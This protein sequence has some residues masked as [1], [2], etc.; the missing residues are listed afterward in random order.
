MRAPNPT[1]QFWRDVACEAGKFCHGHTR[2]PSSTGNEP[3]D[4]ICYLRN[5]ITCI[6]MKNAFD[7]FTPFPP[8]NAL[9][10]SRS[11][12]DSSSSMGAGNSTQENTHCTS[13]HA[14]RW[15]QAN[16]SLNLFH[17]WETQVL[18]M[19]SCMVLLLT[20]LVLQTCSLMFALFSSSVIIRGISLGQ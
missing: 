10:G 4:P 1:L 18:S 12:R 6:I 15:A 19:C 20:R 13:I 11:S 3:G 5:R 17:A 7:A 14:S 16:S 9:S 8:N 2:V